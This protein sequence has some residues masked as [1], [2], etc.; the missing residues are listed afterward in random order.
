MDRGY[1]P[2]ANPDCTYTLCFMERRDYDECPECGTS[3]PEELLLDNNWKSRKR[4]DD[5]VPVI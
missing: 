1:P 2:C 3:I 4:G 5:F